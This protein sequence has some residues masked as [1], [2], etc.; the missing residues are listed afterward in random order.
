MFMKLVNADKP[1]ETR[2]LGYTPRP[3]LPIF[4][5]WRVLYARLKVVDFD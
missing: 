1:I 3:D 5:S 4:R 2:P